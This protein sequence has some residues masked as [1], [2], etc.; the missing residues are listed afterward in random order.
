VE[1]LASQNELARARA[2]GALNDRIAADV[3]D[4]DLLHADDIPCR[5]RRVLF[6]GVDK[7]KGQTYTK[8]RGVGI[9]ERR[10]TAVTTESRK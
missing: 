10:V 8:T 1:A 7:Q 5:D 2:L 3:M 9:L 6:G 4:S